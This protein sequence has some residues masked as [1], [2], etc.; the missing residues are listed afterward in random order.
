VFLSAGVRI[1]ITS[2]QSRAPAGGIEACRSFPGFLHDKD[3]S[4]DDRQPSVVPPLMTVE[5]AEMV[6]TPVAT[7]LLAPVQT[8]P[9]S[10]AEPEMLVRGLPA[11]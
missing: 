4:S 7:D 3:M 5:P 10:L 9:P 1:D 8:I 2:C 11:N 6:A